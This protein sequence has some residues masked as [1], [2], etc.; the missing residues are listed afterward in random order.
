[1]TS[2]ANINDPQYGE[3]YPNS[4]DVFGKLLEVPEDKAL[5]DALREITDRV[6]AW[7]SGQRPEGAFLALESYL[8]DS[9]QFA[10]SLRMTVE[11]PTIDPI[12]DFLINRKEG[13]CEYYASALTMLLRIGRHL[14]PHGQRLQGGGLQRAGPG[15]AG[16][17]EARAQLGR[18]PGRRDQSRTERRI[19][20]WLTLDPTP[21]LPRAESVARVGGLADKFRFVSDYVR[22]LWVF[23]VVGFNQERQERL[24]YGPILQLVSEAKN[25]FAIMG[26]VLAGLASRLLHFPDLRSFFSVRGFFVSFF[27][28]LL[29]VGIVRVGSWLIRRVILRGVL[30]TRGNADL[31][32]GVA[33]YRRLV[34][35][36]DEHGLRRPPNETPREFANRAAESLAARSPDD[37]DLA[38]VPVAVV[39][40]FYGIR[41]GDRILDHESH[42]NLELRLDALEASLQPAKA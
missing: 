38:A 41:F 35:L 18:G 42:R 22:Y 8:R 14:G 7:N 25:G 29:L 10:Y 36:L 23:Y 3:R 11:D 19:P 5:R 39:D 32:S 9:G 28:L 16:P 26:T 4:R 40:A 15:V 13:H 37:E 30:A 12:A 2:S 33:S 20:L 27:A 24:I 6:L 31:N 17:P 1:M 21:A 34:R